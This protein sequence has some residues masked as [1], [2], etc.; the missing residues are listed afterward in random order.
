MLRVAGAAG[1]MSSLMPDSYDSSSFG[2]QLYSK[3]KT[4]PAHSFGTGSRETATTKVF[5]SAKHERL[6]A[7][8]TS[9]GPAYNVPSTVGAASKWSF[10][11]DEQRK[12]PKAKY[13]DSSVD[14]VCAD[15]DTQKLKYH[16]T[17]LVHFGTEAKSSQANAETIKVNP[18]MSLGRDAPGSLEYFAEEAEPKVAKKPPSYSFAPPVSKDKKDKSAKEPPH[19]PVNRLNLNLT[20]SP[21]T[22]GPGSHYLDGSIGKQ[23][24]SARETRPAYSMAGTP[25][26]EVPD[27][28]GQILDLS[29][30]LSS[31]GKQVVSKQPTRPRCTFG[32]ATRDIVARTQLVLHNADRGPAGA[33]P[34]PNHSFNMPKAPM[35]LPSK[36]GM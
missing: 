2:K 31:L 28:S 22:L 34:K 8:I 36:V 19:K 35:N 33:M 10:G 26:L 3:Q 16:N 24:R 5:I 25:R 18:A 14:L 7:P 9:P 15:T 6:K 4:E 20:S 30:D 13:P 32:E 11:A 12:H 27:K 29:P 17:K 23:P 1:A 21:C